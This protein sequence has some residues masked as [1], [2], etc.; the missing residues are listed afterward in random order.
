MQME[1]EAAAAAAAEAERAEAARLAQLREEYEA[2]VPEEIKDRVAEA[3]ERELAHLKQKME[4]QFQ[5]QH[6]DILS[7]LA[8]FEG[9]LPDKP[10]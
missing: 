2:A 3:V 9:K 1:E 6:A 5:Q 10:S 8:A 4:A 7:S